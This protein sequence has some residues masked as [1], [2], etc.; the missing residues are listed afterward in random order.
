MRWRIPTPRFRMKQLLL[1]VALFA[2]GL[3]A[4]REYLRP[5]RVWRRGI[6]DRDPSR[7]GEAWG[8]GRR[9]RIE[10]MSPDRSVEEVA[11][12]LEDSDDATATEAIGAYP[13]IESDSRAVAERLALRL[14][15]GNP[16][17]RRA[18]ATSIRFAVQP[19]RPGRE[20]AF[21]ALI[22]ALDDP[23]AGVRMMAART[24]GEISF[25]LGP[26]REF[27][28]E[29]SL[30]KL[31][32]DGNESVRLT[33]ALAMT[34]GGGGEEAVPML[35]ES[36]R[37]HR[38]ENCPRR[39]CTPAFEALMVLAER[40]DEGA[41]A[42][43]AMVYREPAG[44]SDEALTALRAVINGDLPARRRVIARAKLALV[45]PE[46]ERRLAAS[47]LLAE[48]GESRAAVLG[49][50]EAFGQGSAG[51]RKVA[52]SALRV[53]ARLDPQAIRDAGSDPALGRNVREELLG[54][55]P[56]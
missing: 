45:R 5:D 54:F 4:M 52:D 6:H 14:L 56:E 18:A 26:S 8:E 55:I 23:D 19:G 46:A 31:L 39:D 33:A 25:Q 34:R 37:L 28:P 35:L 36:L 27:D 29:K 49:L 9:G 1:L 12:A 15:D 48:I 2:L 17:V 43:I 41:S 50:V 42:L 16:G 3:T 40:S 24:L 21:P 47:L 22:A 38:D 30:R 10:G 53:V 32:V 44:R 7:R 13:L 20:V 51:A 11:R